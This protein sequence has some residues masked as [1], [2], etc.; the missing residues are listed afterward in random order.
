MS[1]RRRGN[2]WHAVPHSLAVDTVRQCGPLPTPCRIWRWGKT[3]QGYGRLYVG[4]RGVG[5]HRFFFERSGR[6]LQSS[7]HLDHLCRTPLCVNPQHLQVVTQAENARRG[8]KT[9]LDAHKVAKIRALRA[10]GCSARDIGR[11]FGVSKWT[12]FDITNGKSWQPAGRS[13]QGRARAIAEGF[14]V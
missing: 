11:L 7:D 12:I 6:A 1:H 10:K 13:R 5:A 2:R 4:G 14:L 9:K 8:A 3:G